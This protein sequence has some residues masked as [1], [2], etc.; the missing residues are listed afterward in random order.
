MELGASTLVTNILVNLW[1][2]N[3]AWI[4]NKHEF[5]KKYPCLLQVKFWGQIF[6]KEGRVVIPRILLNTIGILYNFGIRY[7]FDKWMS[8]VLY[9]PKL[10]VTSYD[11]GF[12]ILR[13]ERSMN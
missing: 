2:H 1:L 5:I 12:G 10:R 6:F 7:K 9:Y 4:L 3:K 11:M 13:K 8:V